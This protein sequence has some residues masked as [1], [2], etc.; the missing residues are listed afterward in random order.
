MCAFNLFPGEGTGAIGPRDFAVLGLRL[1][2]S[3]SKLSGFWGVE[4][5]GSKS[6]ME[7]GFC[8]PS[9][10]IH[11]CCE[12]YVR[13]VSFSTELVGV[14]AKE[15]SAKV[16]RHMRDAGFR[17]VHARLGFARNLVQ[18]CSQVIF[19]CL[20]G[21]EQVVLASIIGTLSG[22]GGGWCLLTLRGVGGCN[23]HNKDLK[24]AYSPKGPYD[25]GL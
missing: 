1:G 14:Q 10:T 22:V 18:D 6:G 2:A 19:A 3:G 20:A 4:G 7:R 13:A 15:T 23:A 12:P 11:P 21:L 5:K 24:R 16:L 25:I 8:P 9:S 17:I